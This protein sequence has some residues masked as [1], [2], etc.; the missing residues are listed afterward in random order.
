M[1][2]EKRK[3]LLNISELLLKQGLISE[4][5]SMNMRSIINK[6]V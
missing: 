3:I 2:N 1:E 4:T 6:D 5:E